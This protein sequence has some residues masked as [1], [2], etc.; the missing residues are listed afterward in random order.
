MQVKGYEVSAAILVFTLSALSAS[1]EARPGSVTTADLVRNSLIES[2]PNLLNAEGTPR[3]ATAKTR[4]VFFDLGSWHGFGLPDR[5][6]PVHQ[7]GFT[8]PFVFHNGGSWISQGLA[9][10]TLQRADTHEKIDLSKD[11][12]AQ[13]ISYPGSLC[14]KY[15]EA[16]LSI[17]LEL[18]FVSNRSAIISAR[19]SNSSSQDLPLDVGWKGDILVPSA[20]M[21][22]Q[23]K[24]IRVVLPNSTASVQIIFGTGVREPLI[25]SEGARSY[26]VVSARPI[27]LKPGRSIRTSI[28]ESVYLAEAEDARDRTVVANSLDKPVESFAKAQKRWASYLKPLLAPVDS[29]ADK[30]VRERVIVKSVQTLIGNWRSPAGDLTFDGIF[31]SWEEFQGFWAW[32]S[33]KHAVAVA[34][35]APELAK[36]QVRAMFAYQ[37]AAGM[38]PDVIYRDRRLNNLRNTK[39]PLAA[40]AVWQIYSATKDKAFVREM[41]PKLV[42]YHRWWYANRDHDGNA[43]CEYGAT[44]SSLLPAKWESG[45]DNAVRFDG[46]RILFNRE[47][48][49]SLDQESVDLNSY[50][51]AEKKYLAK[52]ATLLDDQS[53]AERWHR[54]ATL[55][56]QRIREKMFD[57]RTKYFYDIHL[58]TGEPVRVQGPEGWIPLWAGVAS[59]QQGNAV[60]DVI[61]QPSKFATKLPFPSVSADNPRFQPNGGYWRGPVWLDQA[62]FAVAGLNAYGFKADAQRFE[63]LVLERTNAAVTGTAIRETY[64]PLNGEGENAKDFGWSAS[65]LLLMAV[66]D[67]ASPAL[68]E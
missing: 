47:G 26:S 45:M 7:G 33:W 20:R 67:L 36:N 19:V 46:A 66:S 41:Y 6:D 50:L 59:P 37:N 14:E 53:S 8:G 64:N 28:V 39:P 63:Q 38:I 42:R 21:V 5:A 24:G 15:V 3:G 34:L 22:P 13:L 40:W 29:T 4:H 2:F 30:P 54:E 43:L 16:G 18:W 60:R 17:E 35:F 48:A 62:Y 52:M 51:F 23:Q 9:R 31:P 61:M 49:Y 10:L 12:H 27:L 25:D 44:D 11:L 58:G 32:D 65:S 1:T 57:R 68:E 56:G 55:L